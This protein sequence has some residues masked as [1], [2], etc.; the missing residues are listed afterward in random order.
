MRISI[1]FMAILFLIASCKKDSSTPSQNGSSNYL[2]S[3]RMYSP[4]TQIVDSFLYDNNNRDATFAQYIYDSKYGNAIST[5]LL[6]VFSFP[7]N[8]NL[9][10]GYQFEIPSNNQFESHQLTFDNQN[11]VIKDSASPGF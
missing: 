2:S 1:L 11:R 7:P 9:P 8:G 3:V 5:S 10:T 6:A 4:K